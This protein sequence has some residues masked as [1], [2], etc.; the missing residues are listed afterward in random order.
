MTNRTAAIALAGLVLGLAAGAGTAQEAAGAPE[1][2]APA[3]GGT[4]QAD[5]PADVAERTGDATA[6][7]ERIMFTEADRI[8]HSGG[9]AVYGA[10]CAGCHMP[11]GQG[12]VGAG[13]YPSLADNANLEYPAY[14][15]YIIVNGQ[16]AMPP[17]GGILDDQQIVDVVNYIRTSFGNDFQTAATV[18]DVAQ[19][20]RGN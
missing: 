5:K 7:D 15:I 13:A 3:T 19:A 9:A 4:A 2:P 11:D 10:L 20:R 16:K 6:G 18:E 12:A 17:L 1:T 14:P 8:P